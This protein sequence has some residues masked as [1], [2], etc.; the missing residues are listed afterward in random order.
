[1]KKSPITTS[2]R[3]DFRCALTGA[4]FLVSVLLML[5]APS[6]ILALVGAVVGGASLGLM[7][8]FAANNVMEE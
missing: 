8:Y 1:M 6:V 7:V 2:M 3:N 4:G 5:H